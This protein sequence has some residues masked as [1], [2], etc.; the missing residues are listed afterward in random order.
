MTE[1]LA[2]WCPA[3]KWKAELVN[4]ETGHLAEAISKSS[5][6]E[7]DWRVSSIL[8]VR[9]ERKKICWRELLNTKK[10]G[11]DDLGSF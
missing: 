3:L 2:E 10:P 9:Y 11:I 1:T 8:I 4:N 5:S 6:E 7:V